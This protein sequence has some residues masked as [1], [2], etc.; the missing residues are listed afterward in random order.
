MNNSHE[1]KGRKIELSTGQKENRRWD[2]QYTIIEFAPDK[3]GVYPE[4]R[5]PDG[6]FSTEDEAKVAALNS[7]KKRIDRRC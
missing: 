3:M 7:A 2:C 4:P 5:Y 1:Y 6:D